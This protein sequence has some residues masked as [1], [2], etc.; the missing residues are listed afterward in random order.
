LYQ[1]GIA[2]MGKKSELEHISRIIERVMK[3]I[4]SKYELNQ[5]R[6][7]ETEKVSK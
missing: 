5:Q 2:D 3:E 1:I 4:R 6:Q 7:K